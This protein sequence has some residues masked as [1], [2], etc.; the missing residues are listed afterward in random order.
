MDWDLT[1][2]PYD[3]AVRFNNHIKAAI[4]AD[5]VAELVNYASCGAD[6]ALSAP[7]PDHFWPLLYAAGAAEGDAR[8]EFFPD[9]ILYKSIGMTT[10]KFSA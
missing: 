8:R 5:N 7:T 9:F 10:V 1:A 4:A 6:A 2:P 3:W